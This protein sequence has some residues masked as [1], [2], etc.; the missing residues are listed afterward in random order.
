MEAAAPSLIIL[1]GNS[2]AGKS[3]LAGALQRALGRGTANIGQDHFR[4]TVL[5][6]H[7][8]PGGDNID[9]LAS[10][11]RFC[12]E[13][14]YHVILEGILV[15]EHYGPMLRELLRS[16]PG[17]RHVFYLDVTLQECL[18][19]HDGRALRW[20]VLP[21]KLHDW[22]VPSDTLD[23][24][25]EVV[26]DGSGAMEATLAAIV[27]LVGPVEGRVERADGRFL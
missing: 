2:A 23:I 27:A 16:H 4:R 15:A 21:Q 14:G 18:Q 1:R 11:V 26:L 3:T 25:E 9:L 12:T 24:P 22:F 6:E 20:E 17:P 7:D 19:R 8:V 5:R 13:I 10:T